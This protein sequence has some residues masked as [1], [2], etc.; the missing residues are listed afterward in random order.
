MQAAI[1]LYGVYTIVVEGLSRVVL[2]SGAMI[3]LRVKE[4]ARREGFENANELSQKTGI[5]VRSMYRIWDGNARMI[6]L[7]TLDRLCTVLNVKPSQLLEHESEPD[8]INRRPLSPPSR[9]E[10]GPRYRLNKKF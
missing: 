9:V 1:Q 8:R 2:D 4:V 6:G 3:R 7:K 10:A 5:P